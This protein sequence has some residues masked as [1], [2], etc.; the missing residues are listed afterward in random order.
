MD[1]KRKCELLAYAKVCF[2]RCTSPFEHVHLLKKNVTSDEC[3]DL[4]HMIAE[5][6]GDELDFEGTLESKEYIEQ[7]EKEFEET[8]KL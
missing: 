8:Q 6:I 4:S 3:R 7:A 2:E 1:H 5:T